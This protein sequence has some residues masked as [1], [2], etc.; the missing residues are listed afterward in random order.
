MRLADGKKV[1]RNADY[2]KQII[3]IEIGR[4]R[5]IDANTI[6]TIQRLYVLTYPNRKEHLEMQ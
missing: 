3:T 1:D 6:R 4:F 5:H 2:H